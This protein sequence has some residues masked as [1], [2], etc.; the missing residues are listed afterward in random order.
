MLPAPELDKR[1]VRVEGS[2]A[3]LS[4]LQL[5]LSVAQLAMNVSCIE[6][7]GPDMQLLT[8]RL[9]RP[10][11]V[12][13]TT[14]VANEVLDFVSSLLKGD[15][16]QV[17]MDRLVSDSRTRCPVSPDF[18]VNAG[19]TEYT[20]FEDVVLEDSFT[21]LVAIAITIVVAA[22]TLSIVMLAVRLLVRRRHQKWIGS[23]PKEKMLLLATEQTNDDDN[24]EALN[25]ST[26]SLFLSREV[27]LFVRLIT[28]IVIVGNIAFFL[29]G[30][31]SLGGSISIVL[32]LAGES[33]V[34]DNFFDFSMA[35]SVLEMWKVR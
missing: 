1:G 16:L 12:N 26:R 14:R 20:P 8:E 2:E 15:Y 9:S 31:L 3:S 29:S 21:F 18:N 32:T 4:L 6:C 35:K 22:T 24:A 10:N 17:A 13:E 5:G 7:T 33:Y 30:H 19:P 34:A 23:L 28:P 25:E 11:S 27:P